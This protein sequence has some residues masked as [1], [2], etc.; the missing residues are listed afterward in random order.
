MSKITFIGAGSAR[1]IREVIVDLF[2]FEELQDSTIALMDI[3][4]GRLEL[5]RALVAKIIADRGFKRAK[6]EA[7]TN[8]RKALKGADFVII[9]IMVG[10]YDH[11][12][13][14]VEI[15]RGYGVLQAVSDTT[16]PGAIMR[17]LRTAPVLQRLVEDVKEFAPNAWVLNYSN[18]MAM[19]TG[20]LFK[21]GHQRSVGLCHSI[22]G[23]P[24]WHLGRWLGIAPE[25]VDYL[26]AGINH[27]NFYLKLEHKGRDLYPELKKAAK[28]IIQESPAEK[29]RFELLEYLGYFPAEGPDHQ[30]EYYP[31]FMKDEKTA[32]SYGGKTG[33]G[34]ETDSNNFKT[35]S[36]EI[37]AQ[38][39]GKTPISYERSN[40]FSARVVHSIV[41][42]EIIRIYGN[43]PNNGLISNLPQG[44]IVEVPCLVD[45]N[46]VTPC[47]A[48]AI[49]PQLAAVMTPHVH[50]N[51]MAVDAVL[52]KD[53]TL[54]RQALQADPLTSAILTLPQ[55]NKMLGDLLKANQDYLEGWN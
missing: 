14:D 34:Y 2:T 8:Q 36:A 11:Y 29:M 27:R 9:T 33:W 43:V 49:P 46:G 35:R 50:L 52:N 48:G 55:I 51:E 20:V 12:K 25:E 15:P 5:S 16:G 21:C 13:S 38:I 22:Q 19:N 26:A 6:V 45:R 10:G 18:P 24:S 53:R 42:G 4:A 37:K 1:F 3:D 23:F 44:A 7:T 40:E 41:S 28:R 31:W 30:A 17:I 39:E 32:A 54:L 47:A